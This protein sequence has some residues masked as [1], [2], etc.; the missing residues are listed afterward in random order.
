MK[1]LSRSLLLAP[2]VLLAPLSAS[3]LPPDCDVQCKPTRSC[4]LLCTDISSVITCG[5]YGVCSG[6]LPVQPSEPQASVQ[7]APESSDEASDLI[8]REPEA[9]G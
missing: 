8:C 6:A 4:T 9:R 2:V 7:T 1:L 5:E 3:A